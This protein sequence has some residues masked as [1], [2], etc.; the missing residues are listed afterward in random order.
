MN[1]KIK[2]ISCLL[3]LFTLL[4]MVSKVNEEKKNYLLPTLLFIYQLAN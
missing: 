2:N 3:S 1:R 4:E